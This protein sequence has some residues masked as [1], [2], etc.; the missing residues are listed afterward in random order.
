MYVHW[1]PVGGMYRALVNKAHFLARMSSQK[2]ET[3]NV[4]VEV[5]G[6]VCVSLAEDFEEGCLVL[7]RIWEKCLEGVGF[8]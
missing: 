5:L 3:T 2:S 1:N 6:E 8:L 4:F 7:L